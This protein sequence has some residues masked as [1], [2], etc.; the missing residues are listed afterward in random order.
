MNGF[1]DLFKRLAEPG[2][3]S[4]ETDGKTDMEV[5]YTREKFRMGMDDDLN[6]PVVLADLQR[7]RS[8]L[9]KLIKQGL[10]TESRSMARNEFRFL[11][12][13]LGLFQIEHDKWQFNAPTGLKGP[14]RQANIEA[15]R[16]HAQAG[17]L[18]TSYSQLRRPKL[19]PS[20]LSTVTDEEI[21]GKLIE[22]NEAR[23]QKDFKKADEIRQFL[24]SHGI[25]IEDKPDGTSRWKR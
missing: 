6:T 24:A 11:G 3:G 17:N 8:E 14:H 1:Y 16:Q 13:V 7:F 15:E 25:V 2:Q 22:R 9:N 4:V 19:P 18:G 12:R 23:K 10:S 20:E 21:E 5:G